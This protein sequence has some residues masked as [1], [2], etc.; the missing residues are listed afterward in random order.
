MIR[1]SEK[2]TKMAIDTGKHNWHWYFVEVAVVGGG[3]I[4]VVEKFA[5]TALRMPSCSC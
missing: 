1:D 2:K 5:G 4:L 3:A